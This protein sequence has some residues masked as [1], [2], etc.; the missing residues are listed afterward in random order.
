MVESLFLMFRVTGES[1]YRDMAWQTFQAIDRAC[2]MSEGGFAALVDVR[3]TQMREDKM[4]SFFLAETLK[5][6]Q[7]A[8]RIK[9]KE[10][11]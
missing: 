1:Q 7:T 11:L 4:E 3:N 6:R 10:I 5:V 2:R 8:Q 9:V